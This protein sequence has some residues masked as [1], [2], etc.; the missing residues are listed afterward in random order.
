MARGSSFTND[1]FDIVSLILIV[2]GVY[3]IATKTDILDDLKSRISGS[4]SRGG[5]SVI[6]GATTDANGI[7]IPYKLTG[8]SVKINEGSDHRNGKRY[9]VNHSFENYYMVGYFTLG[10]GQEIIELKAD[11]PNHGG[12]TSGDKCTWVE[13]DYNINTGQVY[14]SAE[15]PHPTNHPAKSENKAQAPTAKAGQTI[16]FG[17]AAFWTPDKYRR[18]QIYLDHGGLVGGKP[19]N[20]WKL[21]LDRTDKGSIT[22]PKLAKRQLPTSGKGLEAEIRMHSATSGD[23]K[24]QF[25][26]VHEIATS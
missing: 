8:K 10:K 13:A 20:Q 17:V 2:G 23:T 25:G 19:S 7:K 18:L 22:T 14:F 5:G 1:I 4:S 24:M 12:C 3:Y 9:N 26:S 11:G 6:A 16:G 21:W 15:Y